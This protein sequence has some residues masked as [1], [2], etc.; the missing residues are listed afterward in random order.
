M[1]ATA[2]VSSVAL[3]IIGSIAAACW[4]DNDPVSV[5]TT[6]PGH[7]DHDRARTRPAPALLLAR[8]S[9][10]VP[11]TVPVPTFVDENGFDDH[12]VPRV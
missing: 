3:L 7:S 9:L 4:S 1:H 11:G 2:V 5:P 10:V 12:T 8:P 6:T